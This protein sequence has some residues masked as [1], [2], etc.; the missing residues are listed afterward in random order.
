[1]SSDVLAGRLR[2]HHLVR[3]APAADAVRVVADVTGLHAQLPAAAEL[4]L[5]ARVE[6]LRPGDVDRLLWEDRLLVRTWAMRGTIHLLP[7]AELPLY[8]AA[9]QRLRPRHHSGAWL[10][11]HGLTREQA[12]AMLAAIPAALDGPPL[13][14]E[15]LAAE[16]ARRTGHDVLADKLTGGFGDL[17]KPAAF[18]GDLCFA[19]PDGRL[20][21]F[22]RPDRWLGP[23]ERVDPAAGA[24]AVT[25]RWLAAYGPGTREHL[26]R[27][28]G[29]PSPAEAG[30]WLDLL[31]DDAVP[32]DVDG[33][34]GRRLR[35]DP[36]AAA[37]DGVAAGGG[38]D[39]SDAEAAAGDGAAAADDA[40]DGGEGVEGVVRLLPAFD[41]YVV[42][43]PRDSAAVL[44]PEHRAAVHRPQGWISPVLLVGGRIAGTW[45]DE[46]TGRRLAV[47]VTPFGAV[48]PPV[49]AG[50]EQE[51]TR[52]AA[53]LGAAPDLVWEG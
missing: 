18:R 47:R 43:A 7:A 24:A 40:G 3:R 30:R 6:G 13:T 2:R 1:M 32:V 53:F 25:R 35:H 15:E 14:R 23:Q 37:G 49:R 26:A 42:G 44:A 21:R 22:T 19:P 50:V 17:L 4:A 27:W 45:R 29:M 5:W 10:R 36:E 52:L 41:P 33:R 46:A 31:G 20:V 11:H 28:F 51:A 38:A 16:V 12:E 34:P 39:G 9:Q 48:A 8:T